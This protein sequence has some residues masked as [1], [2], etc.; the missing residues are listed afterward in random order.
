MI[1]W[2][3]QSVTK[4]HSGTHLD[5]R[6]SNRV[7]SGKV[8]LLVF[9]SKQS[10]YQCCT[11]LKHPLGV[12]FEDIPLR[13]ESGLSMLN[14]SLGGGIKANVSATTW[15]L[16]LGCVN[17]AGQEKLRNK[18][19]EVQYNGKVPECGTYL[20]NKS[21][22]QTRNKEMETQASKRLAEARTYGLLWGISIWANCPIVT[23]KHFGKD[24]TCLA[25]PS[26][27]YDG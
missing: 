3:V 1:I 11:K 26:M 25:N 9:C 23:K 5:D 10:R 2:S 6:C 14:V 8:Y 18:G 4:K 21:T 22:G 27:K 24:V 20:A 15:H 19:V 12:G 13:E 16:R 7:L 17:A